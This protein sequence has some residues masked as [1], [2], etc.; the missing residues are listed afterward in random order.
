MDFLLNPNI[1]YLFLLGAVLLAMLSL[2][3]PGTGFF[4]IG[5]FFCMALAG[6]AIYNLS[7]NWWALIILA[8]SL[9]PF[10]YALQKPKR[11]LFLGLSILM[12]VGGSVFIFSSVD[13]VSAVNPLV[14]LLATTPVVGFLWLATRK[15][16]E[17]AYKRPVHDLE[18]LIGQIGEARTNIHDDGSVYVGREMWSAKSTQPI[19]ADSLIRVVGREGFIL[20]VEKEN[21]DK[22]SE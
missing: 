15:A 22:N 18:A 8:L 17:V 20:V 9:I 7:F 10:V 3:T 11:E 6:Y 2:A 19:S 16:I 12:L 4:E 5:A 21:L 1:A 13:G 14:A